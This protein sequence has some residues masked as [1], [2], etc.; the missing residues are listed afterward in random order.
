MWKPCFFPQMPQGHR[1]K[2]IQPLSR[3]FSRQ[4]MCSLPPRQKFPWLL[5]VQNYRLKV[6]RSFSSFENMFCA[7]DLG[8]KLPH[9]P[10]LNQNWVMLLAGVLLLLKAGAR[11]FEIF[12]SWPLWALLLPLG[13]LLSRTTSTRAFPL[14]HGCFLN[15]QWSKSHFESPSAVSL[16]SIIQPNGMYV[17][18]TLRKTPCLE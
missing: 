10:R 5:S 8:M 13:T 7:E 2:K 17:L 3:F 12:K 11:P 16:S 9:N 15:T 4:A 1:G 14:S 18:W 6:G